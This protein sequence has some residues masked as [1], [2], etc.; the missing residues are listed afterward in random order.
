MASPLPLWPWLSH[1]QDPS[2][3][4]KGEKHLSCSRPLSTSWSKHSSGDFLQSLWK[5][6]FQ[7]HP[8]A[9]SGP[10][11]LLPPRPPCSAATSCLPSPKSP[12]FAWTFPVSYLQPLDLSAHAGHWDSVL[13]PSQLSATVSPSVGW[14]GNSLTAPG[15]QWDSTMIDDQ[16]LKSHKI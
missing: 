16:Q 1:H 8:Q 11:S 14:D 5:P 4:L 7:W 10:L 6:L 9:L 12:G 13:L 2:P 15:S 3:V